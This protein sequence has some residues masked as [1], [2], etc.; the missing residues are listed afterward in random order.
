MCLSLLCVACGGSPPRE[1]VRAVESTPASNYFVGT[2]PVYVHLVSERGGSW[3]FT[4]VT[5]SDSPL[6]TGFLVRLNDLTP[7]FDI[8]I[9]ECVLQVYPNTHRCSPSHPFRDK[10]VGMIDRIINGKIIGARGRG[11]PTR[12]RCSDWRFCSRGC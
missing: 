2:Q 9:A 4:T 8:R 7:V 11:Y 3:L 10:D 1:N 5:D 6:E 12:P